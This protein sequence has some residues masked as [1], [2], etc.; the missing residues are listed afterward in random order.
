MLKH[1]DIN[2][3]PPTL[4][5][6]LW[7][8]ID[9]SGGPDACWPYTGRLNRYGYGRISHLDTDLQAHRVAYEELIGPIPDGLVLD[10]MCHQPEVCRDWIV[11]PHRRCCNPVHL[12][13]K[14]DVENGRR[15]RWAATTHC[16]KNHPYDKANTYIYLNSEGEVSRS[17]RECRR[18]SDRARQDT[19]NKRRQSREGMQRMRDRRKQLVGSQ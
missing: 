9:K 11:C 16:P 1:G 6:R 12:M 18:E 8:R 5:E 19:D 4:A 2:K 14:T 7:S 15:N 17:C 10:H 13:P 3:E